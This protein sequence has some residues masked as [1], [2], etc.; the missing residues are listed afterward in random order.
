MA[1]DTSSHSVELRRPG[2]VKIV[3]WITPDSDRQLALEL[4]PE[5]TAAQ[6]KNAGPTAARAASRASTTSPSPP[7][8]AKTFWKF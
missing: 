5:P 2:F 6:P 3:Q 7:S 4:Q 8:S 1:P